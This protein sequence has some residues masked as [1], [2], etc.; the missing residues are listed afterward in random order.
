MKIAIFN[1][2]TPTNLLKE[3]FFVEKFF[4]VAAFLTLFLAAFQSS[5]AQMQIRLPDLGGNPAE[6]SPISSEKADGNFVQSMSAETKSNRQSLSSPNADG[7]VDSTFSAGVAEGFGSVK[8][9]VVQPDGK[10]IIGGS[11]R[12][13]NGAARAYLARFNADGSLDAAFNQNGAGPNAMINA[14]ALQSD[15]KILI[16]GNGANYNDAFYGTIARLN[17]DGTPDASF[18]PSGSSIGGAV[19]AIVVQSDGKIAVGGSF[20]SYNGTPRGNIV[21]LNAD[22]SLDQ[23]FN[24]GSGFNNPVSTLVA[25]TDGKIIAG[26]S[27]IQYN[28]AT[29]GRIARLNADGSLDA[30][31]AANNNGGANLN[32]EKILLQPDGKILAAGS[33]TQFGGTATSFGL[34]RLNVSGTLENPF[35]TLSVTAKLTAAALLPDGSILVGGTF[36]TSFQGMTSNFRGTSVITFAS[37]ATFQPGDSDNDILSLAVQADGKILVGGSFTRYKSQERRRIA[38]LNTDGAIDSGFQAAATTAGI[39]TK[40][41]PLA[42]GNILI[43]GDFQFVNGVAKRGLARLNSAGAIDS[44]FNVSAGSNGILSSVSA[45]AV[46]SNGKIVVGGVFADTGSLTTVRVVRLNEDGSLDSSFSFTRTADYI[47][48]IKLQPDGKILVSGFFSASGNS[49]ATGILRINT[50]GSVDTAFV[51]AFSQTIQTIALQTDGK[52]L[53]GGQFSITLSGGTTRCVARLNADGTLD[54]TFIFRSTSSVIVTA[55]FALPNGKILLGGIDLYNSGGMPRSILRVL[56]NG[57]IDQTFNKTGIGL[58]GL[59]L[60]IKTQTDGKILVGGYFTFYE[61][62][63]VNRVARLNSD[64]TLDSTFNTGSGANDFVDDIAFQIDGKILLGGAFT[65]FNNQP[66]QGIVR[67]NKT[68][69]ARKAFF[70]FDG[71]GKSD[72]SV[73]RPSSGAWYLLNSSTGFSG[74]LFGQAGDKIVPADFDGDGKTDLAVYRGGIWYLQRSNLGFFGISFGTNED[75]P[76]PADFDGDGKADVAVFRPSNGT[77]YLQQSTAGFT[78]INFGQTGDKPMAADFDGDG[79][80]DLAVFR[81]SVGTWYLQRSQLEFAGIQF[82]QAGDVPVAADYDGDG[83]ADIAVFRPSAG[84]WYFNGSQTGFTGIQFGIS[85]D[86]PVPADFDGDGKTDVAVYRN[87]VWYLNRS[88]QGFTGVQFGEESDNPAPNAFVR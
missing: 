59:I 9:I 80:S 1:V 63:A 71:D 75:V 20:S 13:V 38:R 31:F 77:W 68:A 2:N 83:K 72:I 62:L 34:V 85:T 78:A 50:D 19:N 4:T 23:T 51:S 29:V 57:D 56:P 15:G 36:F 66:K 67:L 49:G 32:I 5:E 26:G 73:F 40:I 44:T 22:G 43:G 52:I 42:G 6:T 8:T 54:S 27:F 25:Q 33:F 84:S 53:I 39:V 60:A 79:K 18:N 7:D 41:A 37:S 10:I 3:K 30:G 24:P 11:F 12:G 82:G 55:I 35:P 88:T 45:F 61:G 81:P 21:R 46:Q 58:N 86:L 69:A 87:G 48:D 64:G 76:V 74:A 16:G 28:G 17:A 65:T 14:V 47:S 70:D